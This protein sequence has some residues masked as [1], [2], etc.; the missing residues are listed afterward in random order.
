MTEGVALT[1]T[2]RRSGLVRLTVIA[3]AMMTIATLGTYL[4]ADNLPC[5]LGQQTAC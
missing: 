2:I 1:V 3:F 4:V 5:L